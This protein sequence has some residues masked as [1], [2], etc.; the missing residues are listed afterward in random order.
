M[1]KIDNVYVVRVSF[2]GIAQL[3]YLFH[4]PSLFQDLSIAGMY[5]YLRRTHSMGNSMVSYCMLLVSTKGTL[6]PLP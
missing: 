1:S 5:I 4:N 3:L 2:I 6:E